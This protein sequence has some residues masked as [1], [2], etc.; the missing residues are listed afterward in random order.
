MDIKKIRNLYNRIIYI[1]PLILMVCMTFSG[2]RNRQVL[3]EVRQYEADPWYADTN[4]GFAN[5]ATEDE[6]AV[7]VILRKAVLD[8]TNDSQNISA[9][10]ITLQQLEKIWTALNMDAPEIFWVDTFEYVSS[11]ND[12]IDNVTPVYTYSLEERNQMQSE[13]D[14]SVNELISRVNGDMDDYTKIKTIHD[15]LIAV[16]SYN[17]AAADNQNIYSVFARHESVCAGYSKAFQY[18]LKQTGIYATIVTGTELSENAPH[19]WNIVK[20][21]DSY[22]QFDITSDD[23]G[24]DESFNEESIGH[25]FFAITSEEISRYHA[26]D[27]TFITHPECT[28]TQYNYYAHE[29]LN[30]SNVGNMLEQMDRVIESR[31]KIFEARL[32]DSMAIEDAIEQLQFRYSGMGMRISYTKTDKIPTLTF[33]LQYSD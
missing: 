32:P 12:M 5:L 26:A 27:T 6:K 28:A 1:L 21:G 4:S 9:Y 31:G 10:H 25:T 29:G 23:I 17:E 11:Y 22:Y 8:Q 20:I 19:C 18:V 13:I 14:A 15:T 33:F 2:C 30:F 16:T 7:Y 3:N 24:Y